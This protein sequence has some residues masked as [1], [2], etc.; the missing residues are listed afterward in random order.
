MTGLAERPLDALLDLVAASD[1]APG[2]GSSA[3]LAAALGAALTE[4]TA[5]LAG[6]DEAG[7]RARELRRRALELADEDLSSYAKVID[8]RRLSDDNPEK[9]AR[10]EA[11]LTEASRCP[12]EIAET[13]AETAV[14][15]AE[16]AEA[17][18]V[19]VRGDAVAGVLIAVA[20][21]TA[22]ATLVEINLAGR[23]DDPTLGLTREARRTAEEARARALAALGR[24]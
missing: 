11:A 21:A 22:A 17:S 2:G 23:G 5:S 19:A 13:A 12:Q 1:P 6:A 4:M 8:A 18:K 14:L 3:A 24:G 10:V 7:A 16:I 9:G 20:A 15:G